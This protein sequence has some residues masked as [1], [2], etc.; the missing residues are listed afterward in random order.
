M[1]TLG[2]RYGRQWFCNCF[3]VLFFDVG[4]VETLRGVTRAG[5]ASVGV[6]EVV[7]FLVV[8]FCVVF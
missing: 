3:R 2:E 6:L 5:Y 8:N 1:F 7:F 4:S